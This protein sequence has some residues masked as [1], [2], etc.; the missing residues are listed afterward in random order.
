M[1]IYEN[2]MGGVYSS[3]EIIDDTYCEQCGDHDWLLGRANNKE[4]AWNLLRG[5]TDIDGSG[6]YDYEYMQEFING[7]DFDN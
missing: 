3:D 2:H 4:E 7:L 5:D 6:G 1:F